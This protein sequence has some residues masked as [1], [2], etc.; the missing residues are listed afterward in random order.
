M[1]AR[2]KTEKY[3]EMPRTRVIYYIQTEGGGTECNPRNKPFI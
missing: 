1:F 3:I 2:V